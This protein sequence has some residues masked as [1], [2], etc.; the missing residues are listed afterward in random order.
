[1]GAELELGAF[2]MSQ[3]NYVRHTPNGVLGIL[4]INRGAHARG[5]G[6]LM[7][8]RRCRRSCW[9]GW[10][11]PDEEG[12]AFDSAEFDVITIDWI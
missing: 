2:G 12:D 11:W 10:D 9:D 1:M 7:Q 3:V 6:R 8:R 5:M 4:G